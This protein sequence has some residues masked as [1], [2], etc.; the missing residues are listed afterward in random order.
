MEDV[1]NYRRI[2]DACIGCICV[3][4]M[5]IAWIYMENGR[6]R[7]WILAACGIMLL[8]LLLMELLDREKKEGKEK[9]VRTVGK[10]LITELVL[11]SEEDTELM[12]WDMYGKTA[13]VIG[14]DVGENHVD[15]DLSISP[16]GSLVEVEHAVLN[17]S[18][19]SWYIEDVGSAN[20]I[21]I[22]KPEDGK[23][24]RLAADTPCRIEAGDGILLGKNHLLVR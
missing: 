13:M 10:E 14:R 19:D 11:L 6:E 22:Q 15:V 5:G 1:M 3:T 2:I 23:I 24:Y 4:I 12:V 8:I 17:F 7:T 16:F 9:A 21:S 18:G 20:G